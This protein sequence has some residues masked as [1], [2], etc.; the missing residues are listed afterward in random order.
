[1]C[2]FHIVTVVDNIFFDFASNYTLNESKKEIEKFILKENLDLKKIKLINSLIYLNMSAM[3]T[4]PFSHLLYFL[5]L[6]RLRD[7]FNE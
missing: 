3:H 4:D 6:S 5:G 1:M 7:Y 2:V